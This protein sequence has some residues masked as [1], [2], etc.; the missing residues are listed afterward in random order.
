MNKSVAVHGPRSMSVGLTDTL[1][2]H[3]AGPRDFFLAL[4]NIAYTRL[5]QYRC[6]I[7]VC[8][9]SSLGSAPETVGSKWRRQSRLRSPESSPTQRTRPYVDR[10]GIP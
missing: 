9:S 10:N 3:G 4:A 7:K 2:M 8:Q 5:N 1:L 6:Y